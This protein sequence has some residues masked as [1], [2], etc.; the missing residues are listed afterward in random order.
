MTQIFSWLQGER[1]SHSLALHMFFLFSLFFLIT[2]IC[3]MSIL[4]LTSESVTGQV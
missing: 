2:F 1:P 3:T 4:K